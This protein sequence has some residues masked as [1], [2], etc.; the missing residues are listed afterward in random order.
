MGNTPSCLPVNSYRFPVANTTVLPYPPN[1]ALCLHWLPVKFRINYKLLLLTYKALH[2]LAPQYLSGLL[3]D[4]SPER[5]NLRSADQELL[6]VADSKKRTLGDRAFCV[7]A[8]TLWNSLPLE[9]RQMPTLDSFK[10]ALKRHLFI[11]A[12][13]L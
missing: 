7:A 5:E 4:Y 12:F 10:S 6:D 13:G 2:A 8:P 1:T 9:I 3:S 11:E